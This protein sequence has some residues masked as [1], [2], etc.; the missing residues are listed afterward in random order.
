METLTHHSVHTQAIAYLFTC[1]RFVRSIKRTCSSSL[2]ENFFF[3]FASYQFPSH[4]SCYHLRW[5]YTKNI[6]RWNLN[7][8]LPFM[9]ILIFWMGYLEIL[10]C[11]QVSCNGLG[12][13]N[14]MLVKRVKC[15]FDRHD[16]WGN[17]MDLSQKNL[18]NNVSF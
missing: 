3:S 17:K 9:G 16:F 13:R 14:F 11:F 8:E 15:S 7:L 6:K 12:R 5:K 4:W 10:I 18:K 1:T 2:K